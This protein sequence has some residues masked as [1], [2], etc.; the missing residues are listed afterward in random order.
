MLGAVH[1]EPKDRPCAPELAFPAVRLSACDRK[2]LVLSFL[3]FLSSR[4][5]EKAQRWSMRARL[6]SPQ[7]KGTSLWPWPRHGAV[8]WVSA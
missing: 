2:L 1:T 8:S 3:Q 4:G 7:A 6:V 5:A